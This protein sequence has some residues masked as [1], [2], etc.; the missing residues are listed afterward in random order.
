MVFSS[1]IFLFAFLPIC[2]AIYYW[3]PKANIKLKN[4]ILFIMSLFF[5]AWGE[6]ICIII[7][8]LSIVLNYIFAIL[9][10]KHEKKH[11][12]AK[13]ILI[14]MLIFNLGMLFIFKYLGFFISNINSIFNMNL[15]IPEIS[16]PIGI[17]FFTFQAISYVIDVYRKTDRGEIITAQKNIIN[18]GLYIAFFPQLIAGPIVRY[19]TIADQ[20]EHRVE[21]FDKFGEGTRRFLIGLSKKV[22][23]SNNLAIIA[24]NVFAYQ[25]NELSTSL[26]WL[27]AIAYSFQILFDFS[28]YSDM[29][30]GLGKMFGFEFM[31]NFNYPYISKSVAEFWR[32]WH[33]SLGN[34]FK[35]YIYIFL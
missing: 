26:A 1:S 10:E 28:G 8:V 30:I 7:M 13:F 14:V 19:K 12:S 31:E 33:I 22:L 27:G 24:D 11:I 20:L 23:L 2:L 25:P 21:S 15:N 3:I 9:V 29:A 18:V 35:D 4:F 5:Y 6:P 17:S 32:R 34:W 16:L